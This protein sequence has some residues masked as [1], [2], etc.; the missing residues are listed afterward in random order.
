[1][2]W[3]SLVKMPFKGCCVIHAHITIENKESIMELGP[4]RPPNTYNNTLM[5]NDQLMSR[6][7]CLFNR[8]RLCN[9]KRVNYSILYIYTKFSQIEMYIVINYNV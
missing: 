5:I 7:I 3:I 4:S 1:M 6:K 9:G 8:L 2:S